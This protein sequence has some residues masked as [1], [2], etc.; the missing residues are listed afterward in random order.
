MDFGYNATGL[1]SFSIECQTDTKLYLLFDE[2]L[3]EDSHIDCLR[4]T[5]SNVLIWEL[6]ADHYDLIT[7]EPYTMRYLRFAC[8]SGECIIECTALRRIGFPPIN[9]KLT[10][11]DKKLQAVYDAAVETFRQNAYDIY[12][13]CP[14]RERAGWLCDSFFTA[15]AE[16][17]LTRHCEVER[18]FLTNFLLPDTLSYHP[19]G[20]P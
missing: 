9:C 2:V 19:K 12:M 14:S 20:M 3:T 6:E 7:C 10:D 13:D 5:S 11:T 18:V 15:R 16:Y 4:L 1:V 17:A 8:L